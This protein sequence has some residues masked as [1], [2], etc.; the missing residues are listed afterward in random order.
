MWPCSVTSVSVFR[1][2]PGAVTRFAVKGCIRVHIGTVALDS[3]YGL[4]F[5][6]PSCAEHRSSSASNSYTWRQRPHNTLPMHS[7]PRH[8]LKTTSPLD[9]LAAP[10]RHVFCGTS[11]VVGATALT[12][13]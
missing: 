1:S 11:S 9:A 2:L 13:G 3:M 12:E 8:R 10:P 4:Q 6:S 5:R 7:C